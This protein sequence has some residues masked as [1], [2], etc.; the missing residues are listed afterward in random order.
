[1]AAI[2]AKTGKKWTRQAMWGYRIF[3]FWCAEL[4]LV[5]E[6][7]GATHKIEY[8]NYRDEYNYRRSGIVVLRVPNFCE[9]S[10]KLA[11]DVIASAETWK[12]RRLKLG[13]FGSKKQK[14]HLVSGQ[15]GLF[16]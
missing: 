10:A 12:E 4:G 14:R 1:M 15:G 11:L 13:I 5:V 9:E 8:D 3:D 16:A 2:L 6:V 7:D